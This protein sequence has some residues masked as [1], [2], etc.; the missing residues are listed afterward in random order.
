MHHIAKVQIDQALASQS[1]TMATTA[2]SIYMPLSHLRL[3][4]FST[5]LDVSACGENGIDFDSD[6]HLCNS[7]ISLVWKAPFTRPPTPAIS[8]ANRTY[9]VLL[10]VAPLRLPSII[11]RNIAHA[12]GDQIQGPSIWHIVLPIPPCESVVKLECSGS[13][14]WPNPP[15]EFNATWHSTSSVPVLRDI[16]LGRCLSVNSIHPM[17]CCFEHNLV[18]SLLIA[19]KYFN[20]VLLFG[21]ARRQPFAMLVCWWR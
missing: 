7:Q 4:A 3:P 2:G 14:C 10:V 8:C 13:A 16:C 17:R 15:E 6:L 12:K 18:N 1:H 20:L 9:N 19:R 5:A 11:Q 21:C